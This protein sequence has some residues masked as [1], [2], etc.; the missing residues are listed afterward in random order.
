MDIEKLDPNLAVEKTLGVEDVVFRSVREAPF[1]VYGL[2][3]HKNQKQFIRMPEAVAETVNPGVA[4][5]NHH[6]AGGRVRFCS[7]SPYIALRAVMPGI[8]RFP[9]MPLSGTSGFD[10]YV[11]DPETGRSRFN[12]PFM[13]P[14]DMKTGYDSIIY[15]GPRRLRYFTINFPLYNAVTD[16]YVGLSA[17]SLLGGGV[18]YRP[19]DPIVYYGSSITQ[20]GCASRPGNC[21]QNVIS[22]RLN[23]DH[24]NLGFS[25]SGRG[26]QTILDYM[27]T[28]PM[29]AFVSDF[30]HN[31]DNAEHLRAHHYSLYQTIR[32]KHPDVPYIMISRPDF[33]C[34][35]TTDE[36]RDVVFESYR[37]AR[38]TGDK[39]VYYIDGE[40][41]FRGQD[42]D[43]CT[44]DA[45]HPND[46]GFALMADVIGCELDRAIN[47]RWAHRDR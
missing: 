45:C 19:L 39:S 44:V 3:D 27:A 4:D 15:V 21:Y 29:C 34:D 17:G 26:E 43:M 10:L 41:F 42:E 14:Y 30:D 8:C 31:A 9:H 5:L 33:F 12:R 37:R 47:H 16:V 18:K 35:V 22:R 6:T 1:E 11:D 40:S 13:P 7:D 20:G 25:G 38:E 46:L 24:I 32:A 36:R 23:I 2:Y 28:L